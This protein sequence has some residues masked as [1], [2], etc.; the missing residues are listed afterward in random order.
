MVHRL[1][2][3]GAPAEIVQ[4]C[5]RMKSDATYFYNIF[6]SLRDRSVDSYEYTRAKTPL[7]AE[8]EALR[9]TVENLPLYS[10]KCLPNAQDYAAKNYKT[11]VMGNIWRTARDRIA[12][13]LH[14]LHPGK[15]KSGHAGFPLSLVVTSSKSGTIGIGAAVF[16]ATKRPLGVFGGCIGFAL[17]TTASTALTWC[18]CIR[19]ILFTFTRKKS[20]VIYRIP[21]GSGISIDC[22]FGLV[23]LLLAFVI[24]SFF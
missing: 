11:N 2:N 22:I 7:D 17:R 12:N 10:L 18:Q 1:M 23:N 4:E 3:Y 21:S 20:K 8:Y 19:T 24:L 13:F 14:F 6:Y 16:E 5:K 15:K 9:Q